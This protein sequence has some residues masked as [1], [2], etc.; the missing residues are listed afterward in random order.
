MNLNDIL[1]RLF[2]KLIEFLPTSLEYQ[3]GWHSFKISESYEKK[4][5][6]Y[7]KTIKMLGVHKI[8]MTYFVHYRAPPIILTTPLLT[9]E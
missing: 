8:F 3:P 9:T 4:T 5:T 2:P 7:S 1:V 6:L